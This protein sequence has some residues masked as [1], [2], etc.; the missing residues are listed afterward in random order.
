M[1]DYRGYP[2]PSNPFGT[3]V[4][5]PSSRRSRN[6]RPKAGEKKKDDKKKMNWKQVWYNFCFLC[7]IAPLAGPLM[8]V[9]NA[10]AILLASRTLTSAV[11]ILKGIG[12]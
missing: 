1:N 10:Y 2:P 8:S 7:F 12:N 5:P 6:R 9:F 11:E 4:Y 3:V